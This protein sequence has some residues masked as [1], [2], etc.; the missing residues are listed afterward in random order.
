[1]SGGTLNNA[2]AGNQIIIGEEMNA[3]GNFN[4]TGGT[5]INGGDIWIGQG[6]AP[7]AP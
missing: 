7:T 2:F 5:V 4:M 1:M 3:T 6:L